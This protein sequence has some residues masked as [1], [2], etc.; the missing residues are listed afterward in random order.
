MPSTI[1][2][3]RLRALRAVMNQRQFVFMWA[4]IAFA[5]G[6]ALYFSIGFEPSLA[7]SGACVVACLQATVLF[8]RHIVARHI[9]MAL[10]LAAFGLFWANWHTAR[11]EVVVLEKSL[12][13]KMI[14][15]T[16]SA[17]EFLPLGQRITLD[18]V[19]IDG[20]DARRTPAR[21]RLS[22]RA[23]KMTSMDIGARVQL[24][25]GLLPP[26][27]PILKSG[28]DFSR[29]FYFRGIGAVGYG[30]N[31]VTVLAPP[32]LSGFWQRWEDIRVRLTKR[33]RAVLSPEHAAIASGL[34]TGD[35]AGI[36][37]ESY[38]A[39]KA[40]N[41]LHIIAI[42]GSHMVVIAGVVFFVM[43]MLLL[44]I[45]ALGGRVMAKQVAAAITMVAIS[46]YL[47][48]TGVDV[49]ALRA[50][51][52]VMFLLLSVLVARELQPMRALM[53]TALIMLLW[54]PSDLF[55][56][57]FQLSFAATMAML[58]VAQTA[59]M[60]DRSRDAPSLLARWIYALPWLA[61]ISVIAEAVTAPLV[62][63]MFNQFSVYGIVSNT[64]AGPV[65]SFLI[66][67]AVALFFVLLPLGLESWALHILDAGIGLLLD[68]AR[69]VSSWQG[70]LVYVPSQ[71]AWAVAIYALAL[72]WLCLWHGRARLLAVPVMIATTLTY[73]LVPLP[74][75]IV[76]ADMRHI[77][78]ME[79]A[80]PKLA[81]GRNYAM[82][83][84][85]LAHAMGQEKLNYLQ[86]SAQWQCEG[87]GRT[88]RCLWT[89][90]A[91]RV[92]FDFTW[93]K[94][95]AACD[96]ARA[97]KADLMITDAYFLRCKG[98]RIISPYDRR[99]NGAYSWWHDENRNTLRLQTTRMIQGHR[100]WSAA[101][102]PWSFEKY[103]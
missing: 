76:S 70:A 77:V 2:A 20:L 24:R 88:R 78:M 83:P 37:R 22:M 10:T 45:P 28:F 32:E 19:T 96:Q 5:S 84:E 51:I 82:I 57:G 30:M 68:V 80:E 92:F 16:I 63:H 103:D 62:M 89:G 27:G 40:S 55:E 9:L 23:K 14:S 29:Y 97:A 54:D 61:L 81:S 73:L 41:L 3:L 95:S 87:K 52:M 58:A 66:M 75:M 86:P 7:M 44:L 74:Q 38:D 42:S 67:P 31:P 17:I 15:G 43:R 18:N 36:S 64:I 47:C 4:V 33:I 21:V 11:H 102:R 90:D 56:P 98:V 91:Q 48:V 100:P 53:M 65:V 49:S 59:W 60:R 1:H 26:M 13:P 69:M 25:A 72:S 79:N 50:Y 71:P 12:P 35:D 6:I 39:L 94:T 34:I 101:T 46:A 85:M 99:V 93:D 8:R